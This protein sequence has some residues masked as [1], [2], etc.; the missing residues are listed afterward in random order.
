MTASLHIFRPGRHTDMHGRTIEFTEDDVE[1]TA[2]AYDPAKYE[3]PL[4]VGH[5]DT[6]APAYGWVRAL[7]FADTLQA[8]PD[9]VDPAFAELVNAGRYKKISASFYL[10]EAPGN[11]VPGVYYLRHVG[12]LGAVAPAVKG[13]KA[14]SFRADEAGV[15]EFGDAYAMSLIAS[16][17][18]RMRDAWIEKYGREEADKVIEDWQVQS[19]EDAARAERDDDA[20]EAPAYAAPPTDERDRMSAD[21]ERRLTDELAAANRTIEE[22]AAALAAQQREARRVEFTGF[23]DNLV[24]EGRLLPTALAGALA[25]AVTLPTDQDSVVFGEGDGATKQSPYAWFRDFLAAQP[26]LVEFGEHAAARRQPTAPTAADFAGPAGVAID[27]EGLDLHQ[28]ALAYQRANAGT[29]YITAVRAVS[30]GA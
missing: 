12:F 30:K 13:L 16:M 11:P 14:A 27:S 5:P 18:R 2:R 3:A 4:V 22:Q 7:T 20:V 23:A 10:P 21:N 19:I 26:K 6:N 8:E 24:R 17:F 25:F 28:R 15:V 9:Q 29:D 1:A